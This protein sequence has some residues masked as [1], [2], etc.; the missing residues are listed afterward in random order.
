MDYQFESTTTY[1]D[2]KIIEQQ[3]YTDQE[4]EALK[5]EGYIQE[6]LTHLAAWATS[7]E[8]KRFR[9][10]IWTGIS[11]KWASLTG[12]Q[13]YTELLDDVQQSTSDALDDLL[14]VYRYNLNI[15]G[16]RTDPIIGKDIVMNGDTCIYNGNFYL[17]GDINK[18]TFNSSSGTWTQQKISNDYF[19]MKGVKTIQLIV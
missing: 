1:I 17:T 11:S 12:R 15:A 19:V 8:G 9:K 2:D 3:E 13:P 14:K 10:K 18:G 16:I 7:D 6:A 5:N 4:V